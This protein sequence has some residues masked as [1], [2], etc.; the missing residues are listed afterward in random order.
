MPEQTCP[1]CRHTWG[2]PEIGPDRIAI[3]HGD[4]TRDDIKFLRSLYDRTIA[5]DEGVQFPSGWWLTGEELRRDRTA[6]P[7]WIAWR[8]RP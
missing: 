2:E 5:D 1:R 3:Y 6:G 4:L 8:E 7:R